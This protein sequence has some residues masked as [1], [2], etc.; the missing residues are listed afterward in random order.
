MVRKFP[1]VTMV[2]ANERMEA[3]RLAVLV[4][5]VSRV[6]ALPVAAVTEKSRV[7]VR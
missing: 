6:A 4:V 7:V 3:V 5:V 2:A 1:G